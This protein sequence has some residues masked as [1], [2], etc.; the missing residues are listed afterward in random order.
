MKTSFVLFALAQ[1][2]AAC[3]LAVLLV[4]TSSSFAADKEGDPPAETGKRDSPEASAAKTGPRDPGKKSASPNNSKEAKVFGTYD[5]DDDGFVTADEM[6]D[7]KEGKQNSRARRE[8]RKAV[9]RADTNG[10]DKLDV[11]EFAWWY[12]VGRLDEDAENES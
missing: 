8:F 1:K 9:K 4:L 7:M 6:A 3:F 12:T 10:D 2:L 11:K 5:A